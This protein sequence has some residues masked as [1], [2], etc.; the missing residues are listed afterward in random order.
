MPKQG[1][2]AGLLPVPGWPQAGEG[3]F[4]ICLDDKG[5]RLC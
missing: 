1:G 2:T 4:F 3:S 5:G